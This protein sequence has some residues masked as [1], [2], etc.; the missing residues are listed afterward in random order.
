MSVSFPLS[1][2]S[3]ST[4]LLDESTALGE[5]LFP[6]FLLVDELHLISPY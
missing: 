3:L 2:S 6:L 5:L 1:L 4:N